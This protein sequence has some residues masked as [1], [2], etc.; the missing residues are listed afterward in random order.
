M[1]FRSGLGLATE[2]S[3]SRISAGPAM[4]VRQTLGK[5]EAFLVLPEV[6]V[7]IDGKRVNAIFQM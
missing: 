4:P 3:A 7:F 2:M 6:D 5:L 1:K